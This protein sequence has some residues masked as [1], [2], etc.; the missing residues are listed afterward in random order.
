MK[1]GKFFLKAV[2]VLFITA[3]VIGL[4]S[5]TWF[6]E[7]VPEFDEENLAAQAVV[8]VSG[9][10]FSE[11]NDWL[12]KN[13]SYLTINSL[14]SAV[15]EI[16]FDFGT[17]TELNTVVLKEKGTAAGVFVIYA[18][19]ALGVW[20][21]VYQADG[22]GAYRICYLEAAATDKIKIEISEISGKTKIETVEIFDVEEKQS[23]FRVFQDIKFEGNNI[24]AIKNDPLKA[25]SFVSGLKNVTDIVVTN[26]YGYFHTQVPPGQRNRNP[27][28]EE[29]YYGVRGTGE[30]SRF[31]NNFNALK[32]LID[33]T[34]IN[35]WCRPDI[36]QG[37]YY[38]AI[39]AVS[40]AEFIYRTK[41]DVIT[42][43]SVFL[44]KYGFY[45]ADFYWDYPSHLYHW[46]AYNQLVTDTAEYTK[47][48]VTSSLNEFRLDSKAKAV[49]ESFRLLTHDTAINGYAEMFAAV[50]KAIR[51]LGLPK[52]KIVLSLPL[53]GID[54]GGAHYDYA[55]MVTGNNTDGYVGSLG[56]WANTALI[57]AGE[58]S[59][60]VNFSG[61]ALT[62]DYT[63]LS[64]ECGLF[65]VSLSDV[66]FDAPYEYEYSLRK[67]VSEVVSGRIKNT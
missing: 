60:S 21:K 51:S 50:Q 2:F 7:F 35:I 45:G 28:A 29:K 3:S 39:N 6:K 23:A 37:D 38:G 49:T 25:A 67:A 40:T 32:S 24:L 66:A 8:T 9:G 56:K 44:T 54:D 46:R 11:G 19:S 52:E 18:Y 27:V 58:A 53:Y 41:D 33:G 64:I 31:E 17:E 15:L 47:V 34:Q 42:K 14:A 36:D 65:G 10:N 55:S 62:R 30:L 63:L 43:F 48:S 20:E 1:S 57:T 61:F 26:A 59:V 5:C 4:S 12:R 16:E 13:N 22:I